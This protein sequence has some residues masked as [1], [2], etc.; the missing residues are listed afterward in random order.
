MNKIAGSLAAG[1]MAS[2]I[3]VAVSFAAPKAQ[4]FNG[5]IMDSQCAQNGL[6]EMMLKKEG[7][8]DKNPND[9]MAK[10]MCTENCVKMGGKYV[11]FD[12]AHKKVYQLDDQT[13]P[14]QFAGAP[15]KVKGTL[16]KSTQTIHVSD[17]QSGS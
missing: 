5:E 10:K 16:D 1:L 11:L 17:I 9:P 12:G 7:M 14:A 3:L 2:L 15:V 13:K 4:T 8:G 6:H